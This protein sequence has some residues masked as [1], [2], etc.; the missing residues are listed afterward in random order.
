[1]RSASSRMNTL[2]LASWGASAAMRSS[3]R[4][5]SI[6]IIGAPFGL[7]RGGVGAIDAGSRVLAGRDAPARRARP[8]SLRRAERG[9]ARTRRQPADVPTPD[10][11]TNAYACARRSAAIAR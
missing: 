8:A 9:L 3:S 10:G 2:R 4:T 1:M 7:S 6:R 11:P 5:S